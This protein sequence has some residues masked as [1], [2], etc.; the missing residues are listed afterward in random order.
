MW[1]YSKSMRILIFVFSGFLM[2]NSSVSNG[3]KPK[4]ILPIGHTEVITSAIYSPDGTKILTTSADHTAILWDAESGK[5][6]SI[7]DNHQDWIS[8]GSFSADGKM[9][10]T[11]SKDKTAKLWNAKTGGLIHD[12]HAHTDWLNSASFSFSG[13][14]AVTASNDSSIIIWS[15]VTGK[16]IKKIKGHSGMVNT[17]FFNN[18]GSVI[19]SASRDKTAKVWDAKTGKLLLNLTKHSKEL[20]TA[21]YTPDEKKI[22]TA[23]IDKTVKIWDATS[24]KL[25]HDLSAFVSKVQPLVFSKNGKMIL[26][27]IASSKAV[28]IW[29]IESGECLFE[30]QEEKPIM[31]ANFNSD[32]RLVVTGSVDNTAKVWDPT[33]GR[34]LLTLKG[35]SGDVIDVRWSADDKKILTAS[36]DNSVKV[37]DAE[38]G[39]LLHDLKGHTSTVNT[40]TFSPDGSK[41]FT[42][43]FLNGTAKIWDSQTGS[44]ISSFNENTYSASFSNDGKFIATTSGNSFPKIWSTQNGNVLHI[45][46]GHKASVYFVQFSPDGKNI[47]TASSDTSIRIWDALSGKFKLKLIGNERLVFSVD[48]S[49]Q[50]DLLV[51][52][53]DDSTAKLWNVSNGNLIFSLKGHRGDVIKALF[54]PSGKQIL[55]VSSDSTAKVW[56][57]Q[58]GTLLLNLK[59]H[60][61]NVSDAGYDMSGSKITTASWDG[62]ARIWD[63]H[64][65]FLLHELR[66]HTS[67]LSSVSFS[68]NGEKLISI[69][70]D[71][72][73]KIWD[74]EKGKLF[75][76][77]NGHTSRLNTAIITPD[78]KKVFSTFDDNSAKIWDLES[79]SL[80]YTFFAIDNSDYFLQTASGYYQSTPSAA[81]LLH[82][83]T[84]DLKVITFEQLDVKYNR[85]DIVLQALGS[86]DTTLIRSYHHAWQKRI[87]KLGID[88]ASFREGYSVPYADI[89]NRN[90]INVEQNGRSL[91]IH[92]KGYDSSYAIDRFNVWINECPVFGQRGVSRVEMNSNQLDTV[93]EATLSVGENRIECSITNVNGTESY[94]MPLYVKYTGSNVEDATLHFVGIGI[95]RFEDESLNLDFSCKDIRDLALKLK[96]RS[97]G[98]VVID[99]LFNE[100]VTVENIKALKQK[101]LSTSVDDKVLVSYSG[102]GF[103]SKDYD[104]YLSTYDVDF[105][106]PAGKGLPYDAMED[107]LDNIPARQKLMLIDACHSGEVD[108]EEY[109][110]INKAASALGLSRGAVVERDN[111]N[112]GNVGLRNSFELMQSLF[113]NVGKSTGAT[114]LSA[115]AGNQFALERGDLQNGVFTYSILE[116]MGKYSTMRVSELKK[117]VSSRVVELTEGLQRPTFR[118]ETI[119]NDWIIW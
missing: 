103:L 101:L 31:S 11:A 89:A 90:Q 4:L 53:S 67:L 93:V 83:V 58:T 81:K 66:G 28:K 2:I 51:T 26:T 80:L 61:G 97:K 27:P 113:V 65:G 68:P 49:P 18:K 84:P 45:L 112:T 13:D 104:Y 79:G 71:N 76:D 39:K 73:A 100:Q 25:L 48:F 106:D 115:A 50:G 111:S 102:H 109:V 33:S 29:D 62:T 56:D 44:L 96:A 43:A 38:T 35:H 54:S 19:L 91:A 6:L 40:T 119:E 47:L 105:K 98:K 41:I 77:F 86:K 75:K 1:I 70:A 85:P 17:A 12:L 74:V 32:D 95:D 37:W 52:A 8:D 55:T 114:I 99:T 16:M 21:V 110:S 78:G 118:N 87:R 92:I 72:S 20:F 117:I 108:K 22:V 46:K 42:S 88:T 9:I 34:C 7:L 59:G 64:T 5:L 23:S 82:Y 10:I 3:Q 14:R 107:L 36:L 116:A 63:A 24:G 30:L 94:R 60:R 15:T 57:V 69:S